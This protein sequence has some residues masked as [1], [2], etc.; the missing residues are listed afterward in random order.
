[1]DSSHIRRFRRSLLLAMLA[2]AC[3][4]SPASALRSIPDPGAVVDGRVNS[5]VRTATT[6]YLGGY[7]TS[8]NGEARQNIAALDASSGTLM[9]WNPGVDG[10]I[11]G[12]DVGDQYLFVGGSFG[13][14]GGSPRSNLAAFDL[15][16]GSLGAWNPGA[17]GAVLSLDAASK[18]RTSVDKKNIYIGGSFGVAGGQNRRGLASIQP[19]NGQASGWNPDVVGGSVFAVHWTEAVIYAGGDFS[20]TSTGGAGPSKL[21][22]LRPK[23]PGEA[24]TWDVIPDGPIYALDSSPSALYV[25]GDFTSIGGEPRNRIAA[26]NLGLPPFL[27]GALAWNPGADGPVHAIERSPTA[28]YAGGDFGNIGGATRQGV[29]ELDPSS[30]TPSAWS[31]A[32]TGPAPFVRSLLFSNSTLYVGGRFTGIGG[33]SQSGYASFSQEPANTAPPTIQ[34]DTVLAGTLTCLPGDWSGSTPTFTYEWLRAGAPIPGATGSDHVVA[35]ADQGQ[36]LVCRVTATNLGGS[37]SANSA[38]VA[39][40]PAPPPAPWWTRRRPTSRPCS[41]SSRCEACCA[42]GS[43]CAFAA[44]SAAARP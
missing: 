39:I 16:T 26:V 23:E 9:P 37:A 22:A 2:L 14:A 40:P 41:P 28:I 38:G 11:F 35:P 3:A 20:Y 15:A 21:V 1:M 31:P 27:G 29:A 43:R 44:R 32:P 33:T 5:V 13:N 34:G 42:G 36:E 18:P 19:D 30:G 6:V 24:Y 25:G 10:E 12:L 7:F 17:N 4:A 8:V